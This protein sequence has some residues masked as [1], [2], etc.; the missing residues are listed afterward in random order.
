[1]VIAAMDIINQSSTNLSSPVAKVIVVIA[2]CLVVY[3]AFK[4]GSFILKI[5]F[6]LAGLALLGGAIWWFFLR[7]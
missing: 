2:G 3:A 7:Q 1:M 6:G 5:V 4:V